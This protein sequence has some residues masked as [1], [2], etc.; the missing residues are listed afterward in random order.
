M[1]LKPGGHAIHLTA[2]NAHEYV[3][4]VIQARLNESK[5]QVRG[6]VLHFCGSSGIHARG[7]CCLQVD[8]IRRGLA[9]VI[10]PSLLSLLGWRELEVHVCG[11]PVIDVAL[12]KANTSYSGC[13]AS[14]PHIAYFWEAMEEF[15]PKE[16]AMYLRF[17]WGRSRLPLT[18]AGFRK[19]HTIERLRTPTP[20]QALPIAHTWYVKQPLMSYRC[21][22]YSCSY[23]CYYAPASLLA[24]QLF[25]H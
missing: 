18:S 1:E 11:R 24:S 2:A 22:Y 13:S 17:V 4:L 10:P 15:T 7:C 23:Y 19:K 21:F 14:D 3:D 16:R 8:A 25:L 20:D 6:F 5:R 9:R 12:L